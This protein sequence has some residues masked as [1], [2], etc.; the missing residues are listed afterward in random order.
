[1]EAV[2]MMVDRNVGAV[3][4]VEGGR[5]L[6]ILSEHDVVSRLV[7]RRRDPEATGVADLM[8]T[9]FPTVRDDA[10]RTS[11][12]RLMSEH[13]IQHLPVLDAQ[14]QVVTILTLRHLLR[15]EVSDLRQTVWE[16]VAEKLPDGPGG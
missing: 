3:V 13:H 8:R 6:G 1:M 10:D 14:G 2:R 9:S 12:L 4:I 5:L 11:I 7:L 15:A 16:L